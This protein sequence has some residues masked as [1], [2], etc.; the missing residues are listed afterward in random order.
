LREK[1]PW[2]LFPDPL[3]R[4]IDGFHKR[5][6]RVLIEAPCE[7]SAGGR[8]RNALGSQ[9]IQES[10]IVATQLDV[11]EPQTIQQRVVGQIQHVVAF[12]IRQMSLEQL[13]PR[14]DLLG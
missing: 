5:H 6:N 3:S 10:F 7:I 14:I 13:H 2:L 11:F 4:R 9:T 1:I 12:V 8:I